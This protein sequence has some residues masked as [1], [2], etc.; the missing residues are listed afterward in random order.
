M[1]SEGRE[2][3]TLISDQ[4][5]AIVYADVAPEAEAAASAY[6]LRLGTEVC[7]GLA[8][9]GYPLCKGD[10]MAK[11]PR[12]C[13]PLSAWKAYFA[14]WIESAKPQDFLEINMFFDFRAVYGAGNC[15]GSCA[16]TSTGA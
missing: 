16:T 7:N 14:Q 15:S 4:D 10:I 3:K 9:I 12:W 5:N 8:R 6:F 11:S 1:G 13:R 2:E